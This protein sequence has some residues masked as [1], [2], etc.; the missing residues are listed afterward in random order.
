MATAVSIDFDSI[1]TARSYDP[2]SILGPQRDAGGALLRVFRPY[3]G[4]VS[5]RVGATEQPL[6][7]VHPAGL[8]EWRGDLPA[9]RDRVLIAEES[10]VKIVFHDPYSFPSTLTEEDLYLFNAGKLHQ[11]YRSLGGHVRSI[12]G[13]NGVRFA[14]WAPNA[15]RVSVVGAFNRWDGRA[16]PMR[17]HGA[18]GVWELFIPGHA[19]PSGVWR[20]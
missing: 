7:R 18:S 17:S 2:H 9:T 10:G 20:P 14:L 5:L 11:A 4:N 1:L 19:D 16:H 15:G 8:F 12:D 3:A 6:K 13:V